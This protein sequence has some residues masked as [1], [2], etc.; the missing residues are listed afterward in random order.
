MSE[1]PGAAGSVEKA[2]E[3]PAPR[4]RVFA[5]LRPLRESPEYKRL[6]IGQSLSSIG[7]QI[8]NVAV[9]IQVYA[10]TRSS[11]AVGLVGLAVAVPLITLGLVGSSVADAVDRRRLVL[12][13]STLLG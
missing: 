5:D 10:L 3:E 12:V 6:W 8:T 4:R 1:T 7:N 13:T 9:P 11:L 2:A